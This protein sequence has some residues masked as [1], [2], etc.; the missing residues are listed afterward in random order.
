MFSL[1]TIAAAFMAGLI[2]TAFG[3]GAGVFLTPILSLMITPK[4]AVALMAPMMLI[5]DI[6]TLCIYWKKWHLNYIL[7]LTPGFLIGVV[8]GSYYLAWASPVIIKLTIGIIAMV[9]SAYQIVRIKNPKIFN[10]INPSNTTGVILSL[11]AGI[12]SA[13]AHSGGIIMT[14]YLITKKL[15]KNSFVATLVGILLLSDMLKIVTYTELN[16]L[17]RPLL[18]TGLMLTP[19]MFL[20]SWLGSKL[21]KRLSDNQFILYVNVLIFVSGIILVING[22]LAL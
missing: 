17:T 7:I 13:V 21:I 10:G 20:G 9:F 4:T 15:D 6:F 16:L 1:F 18:I 8:L 5:T 12:S 22:G 3:I 11:L 19:M 2:K 14:I